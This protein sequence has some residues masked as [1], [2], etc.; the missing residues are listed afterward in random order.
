MKIVVAGAGYAGTLAANRLAK[1]VPEAEITVVNPRPDFVERV[2]L[3]QHV[4]GTGKVATPLAEML[5]AGVAV[6]LAAVEKIGDGSVTLDTGESADF[7]HLVLAV[8]ST[9][10][11]LPGTVPVGTWE[12][13]EYARTA[14]ADL[15]PGATVTVIGTGATGIETAA[16]VA[17]GRPD[18]RVRLVGNRLAATFSD[19]ARRRV[20]AGLERLKVSVLEDSVTEVLRGEKGADSVRLRS[21][22][23]G[24]LRSDLTLWAVLGSIP[25]LAERSGLEVDDR[26]RAVVDRYL[27]SV[28]DPRIFVV[29]DCAAVPGSR[30]ACQTAGP[31]GAHAADTL[32]RLIRGREP[33]P[34][35]MGYFGTGLTLGRRD[36]VI[37]LSRRDDSARRH[38]LAGRPAVVLKEGAT[39]GAKYGSRTATITWLSGPK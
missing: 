33:E 6:R 10:T 36:G 25:D 32:A 31:Q 17:D 27:R 4:A 2:R 14:L 29:G 24:E 26:G 9:V 18:L 20:R 39:R 37:Q 19:G 35:S 34:Y 15:P 11:A 28:S 21:D 5:R 8:G 12:G 22:A 38:Y 3:H 16:E 1:K 7:D 23:N 13:A 30:A